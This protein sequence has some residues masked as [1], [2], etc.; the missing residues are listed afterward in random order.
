MR[1]YL[2]VILIFAEIMLLQ[3]CSESAPAQMPELISSAT[4]STSTFNNLLDVNKSLPLQGYRGASSYAAMSPKFPCDAFLATEDFASKPAMAVLWGFGGGDTS[5]IVKFS[6]R[7][8]TKPHLLEIHLWDK[9]CR[10]QSPCFTSD[11]QLR[12]MSISTQQAI[13]EALLGVKAT[14]AGLNDPNLLVVIS[15]ILESTLSD[16]AFANL[17]SQ[18]HANGLPFSIAR[19]GHLFKGIDY[20]EFHSRSGSAPSCIANEDGVQNSDKQSAAFLNHFKSCLAAI[21]WRPHQQGIYNGQKTD[22]AKRNYTW[23][24]AD[25]VAEGNLLKAP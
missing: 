8:L 17:V 13:S 1:I 18:I 11:A 5:C 24:A 14:I 20:I 16:I 4:A 9:Q 2:I 25:V 12:E 22:P 6:Q 3:G 10:Y 23:T 7:Y 15:P 21:I 19:S